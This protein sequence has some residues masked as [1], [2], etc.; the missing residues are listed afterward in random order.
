MKTDTHA[1]E[2]KKKENEKNGDRHTETDNQ[3][4]GKLK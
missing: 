1:N 4:V 2:T 3:L